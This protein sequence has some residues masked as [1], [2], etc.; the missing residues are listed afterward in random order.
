MTSPATAAKQSAQRR[1][2]IEVKASRWPRKMDSPRQLENWI[3]KAIRLLAEGEIPVDVAL[4]VITGIEKL[5]KYKARSQSYDD[6]R[7]EDA[8]LLALV[9]K[10]M[11]GDG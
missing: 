8:E 3:K 10:R 11:E 4:G 7:S 6:T 9:E 1:Q 5:T 2:A